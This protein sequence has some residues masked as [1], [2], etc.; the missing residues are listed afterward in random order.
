MILITGANGFVGSR[1]VRLL[2]K[3]GEKVRCFVR[4]D[5]NLMN[6]VEGGIRRDVELVYGDVRDYDSVK[7]AIGASK[8]VYHTAAYAHLWYPDPAAV[9][10]INWKGSKNVFQACLEEGIGKVVYTN[11]AAIMG[12]GSKDSPC[13]EESPAP[14]IDGMPGHYTR[15]KFLAYREALD[16]SKKGLPVTIVSP[17]TPI[18][19]GD[20]KPTPPGKMIVDFLNGKLPAYIG[21]VINYIDVDDVAAGH[22]AAEVSGR[23]GERY[24]LGAHNLSLEEVFSILNRLTGI[25]APKFRLPVLPLL[26]IG[27]LCA[28]ISENITHSEPPVPW[29]GLRLAGKPFA[30]D[31][32]KAVREL[33]LPQSNIEDA[34]KRAVEW[35]YSKGYAKR[36][37]K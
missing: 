28:K 36:R 19:D 25:P 35:F 37:T 31:S 30:F 15:S 14:G 23:T 1:I 16:Y 21:T 5:T 10:D 8:T 13:N 3:R 11:T 18:G 9:Y 6:L 33:G 22:L 26:P 17:T 34:F 27:F 32:S 2:L 24:I 20:Y 29:E 4:K 12:G 7:R